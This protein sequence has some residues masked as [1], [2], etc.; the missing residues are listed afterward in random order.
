MISKK[1]LEEFKKIWKA[2]YIG[3]ITKL[4]KIKHRIVWLVGATI[5]IVL[6]FNLVF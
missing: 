5:F 6:I 3:L 1:A 2:D 4:F